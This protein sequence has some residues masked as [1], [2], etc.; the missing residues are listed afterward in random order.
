MGKAWEIDSH[1]F[2]IK[3]FFSIRFSSCGSSCGKCMGFLISSPQHGKKQ[4][5]PSNRKSLENWFTRKSYKT[6]CMW[7]T[8]EFGTH[9]LPIS[10]GAFFP[11]DSHPMVYFII[12]E[13]HGRLGNWYPFFPQSMGTFLPLNSHLM[14]YFTTWEM[15]GFS[16]QFLI[17]QENAA[18]STL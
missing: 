6:H 5:N 15:Y 12:C 17:A 10:M 3:F 4:E 7:R 2:S 14:V 11:L 18:K 8:R 13:I 9:T 16:H 1:T